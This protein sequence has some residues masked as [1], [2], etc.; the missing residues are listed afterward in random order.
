ME[1]SGERFVEIAVEG[2]LRGTCHYVWGTPLG[3]IP[4]PGARVA[5]PF[6]R[7]RKTGYVLREVPEAEA[8]EAAGGRVLREVAYVQDRVSLV[9][10]GVLGLARWV[11]R[12]YLAGLGEVLSAVLPA[13]V[14]SKRRAA[15]VK[16]VT[17]AM[18]PEDLIAEAERISKRAKKM[19]RALHV[20][21]RRREVAANE[22]YFRRSAFRAQ[23]H[24]AFA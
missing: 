17:A 20:L 4:P 10:P 7:F 16:V 24:R 19:S 3:D 11:S 8:R 22:L 6:A 21:A 2:P 14:R 5:V 13:G 18:P 1:T 9:T 15:R 23:I 12:H